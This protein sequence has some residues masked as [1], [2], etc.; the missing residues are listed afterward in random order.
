MSKC[1]SIATISLEEDD[2]SIQEFVRRFVS[3]DISNE[4]VKITRD[5]KKAVVNINENLSS[6]IVIQAMKRLNFSECK[7]KYFEKPLYCKPLRNMTPE[8]TNNCDSN[9]KNITI[10]GLPRKEQEKA[11]AF[12][13]L[14]SKAIQKDAK[15]GPDNLNSSPQLRDKRSSREMSSPI[16]PEEQSTKKG[17]PMKQQ[18]K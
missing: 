10:P 17:K 8:K 18:S 7:Q 16:S 5:K 14:M 2:S 6:E 12:Q 15:S 9:E 11:S 3:N 13:L 4:H 1:L